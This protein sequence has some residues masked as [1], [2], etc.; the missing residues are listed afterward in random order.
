M[1]PRPFFYAVLVGIFITAISF[2]GAVLFGLES[3]HA[4]YVA[5]ESIF[6]GVIVGGLFFLWR[7]QISLRTREAETYAG[8]L[9]Y[10]NQLI[11]DHLQLITLRHPEAQQTVQEISRLLE[12]SPTSFRGRVPVWSRMRVQDS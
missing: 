5:G 8:V 9:L 2:V 10:R 11:R 7:S 12:I 3:A 6:E 4:G 1:L